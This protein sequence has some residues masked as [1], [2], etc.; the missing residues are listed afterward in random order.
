MKNALEIWSKEVNFPVTICDKD[1]IIIAMNDKSIESFKDD[2]GADLI[3]KSLLDCHPEPSRSKL[4]HMLQNQ[5]SNTYISTFNNH[6]QFV[7]ETP[8][9]ENGEY[10]GFVEIL[11]NLTD[12]EIEI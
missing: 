5:L 10:C 11:I 1:G 8:W 9:F 12:Q 6:R 4:I 2:G 3:G 7:H